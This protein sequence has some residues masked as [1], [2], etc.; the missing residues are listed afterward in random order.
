M[1]ITIYGDSI[2]K[3]VLLEDGRYTINR[4]W[5]DALSQRLGGTVKNRSRFGCTIKK[6]MAVITRDCRTPQPGDYAILEFGGNDCDYH[7]A[8]V[9]AQP[10]VD[11]DCNTPPEQFVDCYRQAI[12]LIRDSG[13]T[14]IM[15]TLP[16]IHSE[17]YL[18]FICRDGLS[19]DSIL[20][21]LGDVEA[22]YR[23]QEGYS[24]LV[25]QVAQTE[26]VK[27]LDLRTAFLQDQQR[28]EELL[29]LDGI[30]PSRQGQKLIFNSLCA[31]QTIGA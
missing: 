29:C 12:S 3:G 16:P 25:E 20:S 14:P 10:G 28:P 9:A 31:P 11:H 26:Q 30:H 1:N 7:W 27:L 13:R 21:W 17:R 24:Q 19:R 4:Q 15:V 18:R 8:D 2:L 22:I 5:E 6:A 23:W